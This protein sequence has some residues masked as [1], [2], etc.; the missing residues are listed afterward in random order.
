MRKLIGAIFLLAL[1]FP[2][3]AQQILDIE[4]GQTVIFEW[5]AVTTLSDGRTTPDSIFYQIYAAPIVDGVPL[6]GSSG[7]VKLLPERYFYS[8]T[9]VTTEVV[10]NLPEDNYKIVVTAY[11]VVASGDVL[12]SGPSSEQIFFNMVETQLPPSKPVTVKVRIE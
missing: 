2:L 4:R 1:A 12:E 3:F 5:D 10:V 9:E 6:W 8:G 7:E 11:R